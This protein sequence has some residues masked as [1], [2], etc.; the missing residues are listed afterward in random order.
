MKI[1]I[2]L[3]GGLAR[4][5][6]HIGVLKTLDKLGI[7]ADI[8]SG[9]SIGSVIGGL[10]AIHGDAERLE[11]ETFA[12]LD[13]YQRDISLIKACFSQPAPAS[14][15]ASVERYLNVVKEFAI[16]NLRIIKPALVEHKPFLAIYKKLFKDSE[17]KDCQIPFFAT[18]VDVFSGKVV[19]LKEGPLYKSALASSS[20][21]GLFPPLRL[22]NSLFIDGG[23]LMP[24]PV[25][26]IRKKADFVIAVCLENPWPPVS[27]MRNAIDLMYLAD[28]LRYKTIIEENVLEADFL[29]A[30]PLENFSLA[31][32]ESAHELV[33][34]GEE[35]MAAKSGKLLKLLRGTR[36]RKIFFLSKTD[37]QDE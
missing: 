21:P 34:R 16:W 1:G 24:V 23:V 26:I 10:Y 6:Y 20:L 11:R 2:A 22:N 25:S 18:A 28:R 36:F 12:V 30:P 19:V 8:I 31:D 35:D 4:G 9:T 5:F 14:M 15:P 13:K 3:G 32:F 17:F 37:P 7:K 27:P 33:R 29:L